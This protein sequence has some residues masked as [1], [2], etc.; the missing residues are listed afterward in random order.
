MPGRRTLGWGE[1]TGEEAR[2]SG[3]VVVSA[4]RNT[5]MGHLEVGTAPPGSAPEAVDVVSSS[6]HPRNV[7]RP[8]TGRITPR[9][10][11][12]LLT[13]SSPR[14]VI[15]ATR[16]TGARPPGALQAERNAS[17]PALRPRGAYP[18]NAARP[19]TDTVAIR[20]EGGIVISRF[21]RRWLPG[22]AFGAVGGCP[23]G[24]GWADGVAVPVAGGG[25]G[26]D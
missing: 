9:P 8:R 23:P 2:R 3:G 21:V 10:V 4:P 19:S 16:Q 26:P 22:E 13:G 12:R 25:G 15:T 18:R 6:A 17:S 1:I 7:I 24:G 11:Q 14:R 5:L 20:F